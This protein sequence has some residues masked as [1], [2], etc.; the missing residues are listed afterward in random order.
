M[1]DRR[2]AEG[3][4]CQQPPLGTVTAIDLDTRK[5]AWQVPAGTARELGPLGIKLGLPLALGMPT[6]AGTS[7]TAGGVAFFA[8]TQDYYL[9]AYDAETGKELA[10]V[11]LPIGASAT[12]MVFISPEN[13]KEYVVLSVGGAAHSNTGD[14]LMAFTLPDKV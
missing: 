13:G 6:Y 9:R 4:P 8:G 11:A 5:I 7:T 1:D 10:K 12:P 3:V 14:Y 2:V